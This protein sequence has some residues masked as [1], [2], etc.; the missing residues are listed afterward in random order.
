MTNKVI[1][2][3]YTVK[4]SKGEVLDSSDGGE[5]M[6]FLTGQD[7]IIPGLEKALLEMSSGDK[8]NLVI[9]AAD[10]Y[11]ARRDDMM[12]EVGRKE[13][14][15]DI[16]VGQMFSVSADESGEATHLVTIVSFNDETVTLD[17]NHPL[18]GQ[19]LEFDVSIS[20]IRDASAEEVEHGHAH[21]E[22]GHQ[23]H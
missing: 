10:A 14:P 20:E 1:S 15:D 7:Q 9:A 17:A 5:P 4:N 22:G 23:H 2:F 12:Q 13:L 11:G 21:G 19:D 3:H 8:K 16:S 6:A 18:A